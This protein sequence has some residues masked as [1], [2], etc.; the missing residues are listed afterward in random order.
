[1]IINIDWDNIWNCLKEDIYYVVKTVSTLG[2][3]NIT[4][5]NEIGIVIYICLVLSGQFITIIGT[6]L[7]T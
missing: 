2:Y 7:N 6:V 4:P 1:M 3:G 5:N